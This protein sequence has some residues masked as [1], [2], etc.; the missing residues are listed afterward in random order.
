MRNVVKRYGSTEVLRGIDLSISSRDIITIR[1]R[2]GVGKTT[3]CRIASLIE[4]PDEGYVEFMGI[5]VSKASDSLRSSLRLKYIGYVDQHYTLIPHLT[6]E[7]NVELP[8]ALLGIERRKRREKVRRVLEMLGLK[9]KEDRYPH[10]LSG[11]ERQRVAIARA[12]VKEP[13]L[14]VMDEPFSNLDDETRTIVVE[15]LKSLVRENECALIVTT[16][17]LNF[18]LSKRTYMLRQGKLEEVL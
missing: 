3:L 18:A 15:I 4:I 11:G 1:G 6:V 12:I 2:S 9:D 7:K 16:T 17:D 8:L 13:K 5:D 10:Q 14:L